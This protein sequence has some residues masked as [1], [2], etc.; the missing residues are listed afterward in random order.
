MKMVRL[1]TLAMIPFAL[2]G[3]EQALLAVGD[4]FSAMKVLLTLF[5]LEN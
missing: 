4:N 3:K 1:K 2:L 5:F